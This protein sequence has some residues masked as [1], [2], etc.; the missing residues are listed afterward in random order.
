[1]PLFV[2]AVV[3]SFRCLFLPLFVLAV[4]L[5]ASFEREGS[6]RTPP[7]LNPPPFLPQ[8]PLLI[9]HSPQLKAHRSKNASSHPA[10]TPAIP[11]VKPLEAPNSP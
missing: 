9:A 5:S 10:K 11:L 7:R 1:L 8:N 3:C 2:L 4:I 6:R